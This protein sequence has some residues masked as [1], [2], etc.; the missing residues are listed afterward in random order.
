MDSRLIEVLVILGVWWGLPAAG[1][2]LLLWDNWR[3][4]RR[5]KAQK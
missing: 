3:V 4:V 5:G 1:L 2:L